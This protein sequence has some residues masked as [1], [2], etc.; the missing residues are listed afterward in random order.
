MTSSHSFV[1]GLQAFDCSIR[2]EC[3]S[4]EMRD[5]LDRYI[6]S[7]IPRSGL[8]RPDIDLHLEE[9]EGGIRILVNQELIASA[10][11]IPGAT[12][13]AIKALDDAIVPRLKNFRA[14]HAGA[15]LVEGRALLLP[16]STHAG[17]SSL[18]AELLRRGAFCFSDEYALIDKQGLIHAYPRP[19]LLRNGRP[20]QT[21]VLPDELSSRFVAKHAPVGWIVATDYVP[22]GE[23]HVKGISQSEAVA[24]LLRNTPHE[25]EQEPAMIDNFICA[26]AAAASYKGTRGDVTDAAARLLHLIGPK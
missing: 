4:S 18:V 17:K 5:E 10:D 23:W 12:L 8:I 21:P 26:S 19:L 20:R 15:V 1:F 16:G 22:G 9:C 24:L 25:M 14:V 3:F 13:A 6:F 2:V 7:P 11:T